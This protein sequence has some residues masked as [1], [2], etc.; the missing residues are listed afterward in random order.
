MRVR[1][2]P[3]SS[4]AGQAPVSHSETDSIKKPGGLSSAEGLGD[5]AAAFAFATVLAFATHIACGATA[6]AL[7]A[8]L[9]FAIMLVSG[10]AGGRSAGGCFVFGAAAAGGAQGAGQK[11]CHGGGD[12]Y[13]SSGS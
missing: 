9:A 3:Q 11:A 8:I 2:K 10:G 4:E 12:D 6:F 13:R 5:L 7:A 1:K